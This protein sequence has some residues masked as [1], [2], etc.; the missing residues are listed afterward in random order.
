VQEFLVVLGGLNA[1]DGLQL[2]DADG[3]IIPGIYLAGNTVGN[4]FAVD[5]PTMCPGLSHSMA[6]TTGRLAGLKAAAERGP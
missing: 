6:W 3:N 5:Y 1:N 4:R 2:L